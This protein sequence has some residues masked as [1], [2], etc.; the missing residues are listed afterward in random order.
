ML[1]QARDPID[2]S[3]LAGR[4]SQG[5]RVERQVAATLQAL[6]RMGHLHSPDAG[7]TFALRRLE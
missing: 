7:R 2:A 1:A 3:A 4:F 5:R 6:A